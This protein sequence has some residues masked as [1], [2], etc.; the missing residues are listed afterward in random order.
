MCPWLY[1]KELLI[2]PQII[3]V[4]FYSLARDVIN[5]GIALVL[6]LVS[7]DAVCKIAN[8]SY[9]KW[10]YSLE[11]VQMSIHKLKEKAT[12]TLTVYWN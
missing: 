11:Q 5:D 9:S 10:I 1:L 6:L 7:Q 2:L 4:Y 12:W 8:N 3:H